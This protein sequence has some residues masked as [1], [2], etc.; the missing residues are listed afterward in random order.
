MQEVA[1]LSSGGCP[2]TSA[3]PWS[4]SESSVDAKALAA[5]TLR[6][7]DQRWTHA[8]RAAQQRWRGACA[9][10]RQKP[11]ELSGLGVPP[12]CVQKILHMCCMQQLLC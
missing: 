11:N 10:A 9:A 2:S 7:A 6:A 3:A 1:K 12:T 4:G 5:A 8:K